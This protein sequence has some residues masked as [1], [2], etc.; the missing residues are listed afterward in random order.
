MGATGRFQGCFKSVSQ[1]IQAFSAS[2]KGSFKGRIRIKGLLSKF[3][4]SFI[5]VSKIFHRSFKEVS[6]K[7]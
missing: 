4:G 2:I 7:C 3:Q 1:V 5:E 6:T